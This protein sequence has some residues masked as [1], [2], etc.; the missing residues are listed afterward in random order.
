MRCSSWEAFCYVG[1]MHTEMDEITIYVMDRI[2][3][4]LYV[5]GII[6]ASYAGYSDYSWIAIFI[7]GGIITL[8]YVFQRAP[9]L[10]AMSRDAGLKA[11]TLPLCR[12][13]VS[14][15]LLSGV[16]YVIGV[17]INSLFN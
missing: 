6:L 8:G 4:Y 7:S 13:L 2:G 5:C 10:Y 3:G 11:L 16:F 17:G 15:L 12:L 1:I 14:Y 9:Q